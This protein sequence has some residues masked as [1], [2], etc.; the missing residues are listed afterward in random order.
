MTLKLGV[1]NKPQG[2]IIFPVGDN[3]GA[4]TAEM[5]ITTYTDG[6]G[7][8]L[9]ITFLDYTWNINFQQ[10]CKDTIMVSVKDAFSVLDVH[11]IPTEY[12]MVLKAKIDPERAKN[13]EDWEDSLHSGH[14]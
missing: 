4:K 11:D 6:R 13:D 12:C 14:N 2:P 10:D 9:D 7:T 3:E 1:F 5:M 8:E